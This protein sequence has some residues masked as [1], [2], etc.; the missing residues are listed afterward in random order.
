VATILTH[1]AVPLALAVGLGSKAISPRL[2]VAGVAACI[3]PDL[4]VIGFYLG[5][6]YDSLLGHR[7]L[8]HSLGF[9][10]LLAAIAL[11]ASR[12]LD[13]SASTAF[14]F[15][16]VA[17]A[18]HGL[19]DMLTNGGLGVMLLWPLSDA[20]Y[21]FPVRPIEVSPLGISPLLG[22]RGIRVFRSELLWV[23]IPAIALAAAM[24]G[25]RRRRAR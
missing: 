13:S 14:W 4:D 11:A 15:V 16:G 8:S 9:A 21:F 24:F 12:R 7:G 18:S 5:V 23:W 20:R 1:P 25:W 6:P 19:I 22:E 17:A 10:L 3:I 2:A